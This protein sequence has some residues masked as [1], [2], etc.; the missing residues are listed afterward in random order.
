MKKIFLFGDSHI[1]AIKKG[2][3]ESVKENP[4]LI[5][6]FSVKP[7]GGGGTL[8]SQFSFEHLG[9]I[10]LKKVSIKKILKNSL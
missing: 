3:D 2:Y 4:D 5:R 7:L 9:E 10:I 1:G 8:T 6:S